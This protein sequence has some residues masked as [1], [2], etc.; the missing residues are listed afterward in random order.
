MDR[1]T[2]MPHRLFALVLGL[3][4]AHS[5]QAA[6]ITLYETGVGTA[7]HD[8]D[9]LAYAGAADGIAVVDTAGTVLDTSGDAGLQA[10]FSNYR[11]TTPPALKND[12]FPAL[13][14]S[15]TVSFTYVLQLL[16]A[17]DAAPGE[18]SVLL[19]AD[20][21]WG[22]ELGFSGDRVWA[23]DSDGSPVAAETT[24]FDTTLAP[25]NYQL[26]LL[27]DDDYALRAGDRLLLSGPVR[28]Y[29][30]R[31][32]AEERYGVPSMLSIGDT[33]TTAGLRARLGDMTLETG[34]SLPQ[35][36]DPLPVAPAWTLLL[37]GLAWLLGRRQRARR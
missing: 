10:G 14:R 30:R 2:T 22:I 19:L 16:G 17:A 31:P 9:W 21:W 1:T 18:L 29:S 12:D 27:G 32:G 33:S 20:D 36:P 26:A 13:D 3:A 7:P 37:P 5:A 23:L 6:L 8:Q 25:V 24:A 15:K 34:F 11:D 28:D 35:P 4:C